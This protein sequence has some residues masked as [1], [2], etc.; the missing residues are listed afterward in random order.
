MS[1][2]CMCRQPRMLSQTSSHFRGCRNVQRNPLR[3][4]YCTN[5]SRLYISRRR[6]YHFRRSR[7]T[8]LRLEYSRYVPGRTVK[9]N[10]TRK[11]LRSDDSPACRPLPCIPYGYNCR[12]PIQ[13]RPYSLFHVSRRRCRYLL[14]M[15]CY[16]RDSYLCIS[17]RRMRRFRT[18]PRS[19][20]LSLY[21][22]SCLFRTIAS[23][24]SRICYF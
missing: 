4:R 24:Q 10:R 12:R 20:R 22:L 17:W 21:S 2:P 5:G 19:S 23:G 11:R 15:I 3:M 14:R 7:Q 8:S 18:C 16:T 1:L 13:A 6:N 9:R